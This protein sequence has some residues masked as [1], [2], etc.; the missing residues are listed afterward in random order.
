MIVYVIYSSLWTINYNRFTTSLTEYFLCEALGH[1]PDRCTRDE[2]EK[3]SYPYLESFTA[4]CR[5]FVQL[6]ILIFAIN[7]QG[8]NAKENGCCPP[9]PIKVEG[10]HGNASAVNPAYI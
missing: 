4:L 1:T 9:S 8:L 3:Y 10:K 6:S 5:I 7:N 2:F